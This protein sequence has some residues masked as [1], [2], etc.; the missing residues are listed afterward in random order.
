MEASIIKQRGSG[1]IAKRRTES[2]VSQLPADI[3]NRSADTTIREPVRSEPSAPLDKSADRIRA[4]FA[5]I[6]PR[7]DFL[8]H[9]L[10]AGLDIAWRRRTAQRAPRPLVGPILDVCTGTGDLALAYWKAGS[11]RVVVIGLDAC[12]PMLRLAQRKARRHGAA[13]WIEWVLGD[14]Q[15]LPFATGTFQVVSVAFGIRNVS[16]PLQGLSE[17]VR[18]CT[19]GG[20]V[21]VL[22]FAFPKNRIFGRL[23]RWYFNRVLPRI[24]QFF[25]RN[26]FEAYRYLPESVGLFEQGTAFAR[27]LEEVGLGQ[28]EMLP[29]TG[30]IATLY[31][32]RK[33]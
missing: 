18:V 30:G 24:G 27:R 19:R 3:N 4:M 33:P 10:S 8:N 6:A 21:A 22:E 15:Q 31:L 32:G 26:R 7:Y 20:Q 23:F 28:V 29:M 9:L 12:E 11:R 13:D 17:M 5:E 2:M 1:R 25:A 16:D 14:T